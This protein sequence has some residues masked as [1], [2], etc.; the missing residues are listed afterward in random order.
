MGDLVPY[1]S[2]NAKEEWTALVGMIVF[3]GSWAMMFGALFFS[4][5]IVRA[6]SQVWPPP[7]LPKIPLALPAVNTVALALSSVTLQDA[8]RSLRAGNS[9]RASRGIAATVVLGVL[10]VVLQSIVWSGL[11][12]DGLSPRSGTYASVFYGLTGFHALHVTV[13]LFALAWLCRRAFAGAYTAARH[14]P[15]RLWT[16]YW[17]F[18][19]AVWFLM[20]VLLYLF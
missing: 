17:H 4:Y 12:D 15:V 3:L 13:G 19:G 20:F 7:D 18:V 2:P 1:R 16:L 9:A 8:V 11:V 10:F 6:H 14:L 5:G